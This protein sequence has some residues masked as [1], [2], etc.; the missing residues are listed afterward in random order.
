M[1]LTKPPVSEDIAVSAWQFESTDKINET[2]QRLNTLLRAIK[3]ATTLAALQEK[4]KK[5]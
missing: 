5:L 2:E 3:E 4:I 1:A